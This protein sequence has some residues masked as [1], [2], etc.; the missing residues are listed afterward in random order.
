LLDSVAEELETIMSK[1]VV[2]Q[3]LTYFMTSLDA[4]VSEPFVYLAKGCD[5]IA[6]HQ[7]VEYIA[8][9]ELSNHIFVVHFVDN[10]R[11][12]KLHSTYRWHAAEQVAA[13][14]L[15]PEATEK[16]SNGLLMRMFRHDDLGG[17]AFSEV[18]ESDDFK[19]TQAVT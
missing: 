5:P 2:G 13:W 8:A 14:L 3:V 7:V 11:A 1:Q 17:A 10:R 15:D 6:V 4:I 18:N 16:H 12:I 9:N 19:L